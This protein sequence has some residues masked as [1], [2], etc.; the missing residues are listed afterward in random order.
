MLDVKY[1]GRRAG[2]LDKVPEAKFP[3]QLSELKCKPGAS[4]P[5][6]IRSKVP[7]LPKNAT[8]SPIRSLPVSALKM[9]QSL[10]FSWLETCPSWQLSALV[11]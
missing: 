10:C 3:A 9:F 8:P 2:R 5:D 6:R 7:S 4:R 11:L 1:A